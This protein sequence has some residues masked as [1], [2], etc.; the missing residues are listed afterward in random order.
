EL[1]NADIGNDPELDV[2]KAD[3]EVE[4]EAERRGAGSRQNITLAEKRYAAAV[5]RKMAGRMDPGRSVASVATASQLGDYFQYVIGVP[6][7]LGRQK[8]A[9]LP[10]VNKDVEAARVS[11]YNPAVQAKHPLLGLKFKNTSGLHLAQGPITVFEGS[12][13]AGDSRVLDLQPNE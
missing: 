12:T 2:L 1:E 8:S 4:R 9:L 7:S 3:L 6:V 11:I 13:Y 10:V 5:A